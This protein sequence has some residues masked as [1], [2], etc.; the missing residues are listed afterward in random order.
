M[1]DEST[2]TLHHALFGYADGHR[3]IAASVRIPSRDMYHLAA[4]SD[5][6]SNAFLGPGESYLTGLPLEESGL[7]AL[8]RTWPAPEMSRPGCV[9]SHV[10]LLDQKILTIFGELAELLIAFKFP[11]DAA[12]SFYSTPLLMKASPVSMP[13]LDTSVIA[14]IIGNYYADRQTILPLDKSPQVLE[15]AIF[16]VWSQQWPR[17]RAVFSFRTSAMTGTWK[18]TY[19][20]HVSTSPSSS[21]IAEEEWVAAGVADATSRSV[22]SL[23]RGASSMPYSK[24]TAPAATSRSDNWGRCPWPSPHGSVP[25]T[26]LWRDGGLG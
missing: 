5:L 16:T 3:Q 7:Y 13:L 12:R 14:A 21:P 8:I 11:L 2:I 20:V 9:W 24:D 19:D 15:A 10:L 1:S 23:R 17:L 6:A 4:A 22:T 25:L 18:A 26:S